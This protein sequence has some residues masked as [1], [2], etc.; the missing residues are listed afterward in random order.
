MKPSQMIGLRVAT[1]RRDRGL[2][3]RQLGQLLEPWLGRTWVKQSVS[4][5]EQ[6][7]RN[8]TAEE[9]MALCV[10]LRKPLSYFFH[11]NGEE[12]IE[13]TGGNML[14]TRD[15]P[16]IVEARELTAVEQEEFVR[17][18]ELAEGA[19]EAVRAIVHQAEARLSASA[20]VTAEV[21]VYRPTKKRPARKNPRKKGSR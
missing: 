3:Q 6:G 13:F 2:T 8:F 19:L 17:A 16:A 15:L 4:L 18:S 10:C 11:G 20:S 7:R 1:A 14:E 5:A 12:V 21:E 9:L